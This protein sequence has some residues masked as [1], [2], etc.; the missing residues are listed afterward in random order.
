VHLFPADELS[1]WCAALAAAPIP[2]PSLPPAL[3]MTDDRIDAVV[4]AVGAALAE[5]DL[6][7]DELDEQVIARAGDWAGERVMPAFTGMWPRWRWLISQV[8]RRGVLCFG[9]PRGRL[10]TY[11]SPARW[12][13]GLPPAPADPLGEV[14]VRYLRAYGPATSGQAAQWLGATRPGMAKVFEDLADRLR[15][16][17]VDGEPA[18]LPADDEGVPT[19][20]ASAGSVR[21]LPYF[22][23][24]AVGAHPRPLV[25]PGKASERALVG[26]QAGPVPVL[27]VDGVVAGVWHQ[28]RS[29]KRIDITVQPFGRLTAARRRD[30]EAQVERIG[31]ILEGRPTLTV[32]EVT[33]RA[34]L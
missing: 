18:W 31:E 21:L 30:M 28:K 25:F 26:G 8:A 7:I 6:T 2:R 29:G 12:L 32:G 10:V 11:T 16:A 22:D 17:T 3:R 13:P 33:A 15:P 23:V 9:P 20:S 5:G 34:H 1:L 4:A 19:P 14:V 24:Y 27:V